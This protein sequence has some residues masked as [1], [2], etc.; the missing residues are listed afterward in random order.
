MPR[1]SLPH[2]ESEIHVTIDFFGA[3]R[4]GRLWEGQ[5][6][7]LELL[8]FAKTVFWVHA[9]NYCSDLQVK[10][11]VRSALKPRTA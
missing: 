3:S 5:I 2:P 11:E 6:A 8:L 9:V 7:Y 10:L 1:I 4:A